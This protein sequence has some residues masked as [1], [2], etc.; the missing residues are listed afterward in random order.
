M[1]YTYTKQAGNLILTVR[2]DGAIKAI[3]EI[4]DSTSAK[5]KLKALADRQI[6]FIN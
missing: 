1:Q 5:R 4:V 2:Q 6:G 3:Y